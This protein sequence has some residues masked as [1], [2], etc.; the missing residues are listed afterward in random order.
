MLYVHKE[1]LWCIYVLLYLYTTDV[2]CF[3]NRLDF[4]A[5]YKADKRV[6]GWTGGRI[7]G[8][9]ESDRLNRSKTGGQVGKC[10][11]T[12]VRK[13]GKTDVWTVR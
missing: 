3:I 9:V 11:L 4:F 8:W 12:G 5:Q 1:I 2:V 6:T 13:I 7:D 10:S